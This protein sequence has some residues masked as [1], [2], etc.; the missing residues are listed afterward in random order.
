M[1]DPATLAADAE[2]SYTQWKD[3]REE[4]FGKPGQAETRYFEAEIAARVPNC[5]QGALLEIGFGNGA[6]LGWARKRFYSV[7][8]V[9]Q[10]GL[11][12]ERA[13]RAGFEAH[14]SI[15][16][17]PARPEYDVIVAMD[18]LEH[19][20]PEQIDK[21]LQEI[22]LRLKPGGCFIA[23]FPNGDSPFGRIVQNGDITHI[24]AIGYIKMSYFAKRAGLDLEY[25]AAPAR[26][27]EADLK[28]RLEQIVNRSTR[29]IFERA[30]SSMYFTHRL[31][32][33]M[34]YV[35][36]LRNKHQAA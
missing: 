27:R 2:A 9:E 17:F 35:A 30:I 20:T 25:I 33:D 3:W 18:V 23:R 32:F 21:L 5:E 36:V 29:Y 28:K 16:A 34:N 8:G 31:N 11:L 7:G 4:D 1:S 19:L 26:V 10:S 15:A 24:N 14:E 6:L 22:V 13:R 12:V